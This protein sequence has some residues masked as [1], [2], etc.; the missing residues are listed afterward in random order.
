MMNAR[1]SHFDNAKFL[2]IV[3][4]VEGHAIRP[5]I[6]VSPALKAC[7]VWVY[8]FH[9]PAFS[10]LAGYF[11]DSTPSWENLK[12]SLRRVLL[13]YGIFQILYLLYDHLLFHTPLRLAS[14]FQPYWLMWF[15]WS[16]FWWRLMLWGFA[17]LKWPWLWALLVAVGA[18][19]IKRIGD[20]PALFRTLVFFPFFLGGYLLH[21]RSWRV[22]DSKGA[23]IFAALGLLGA[24]F[25]AYAF[26]SFNY[27]WLYGADP[28]EFLGHSGWTA[29]WTRLAFYAVSGVL[30]FAFLTLVPR[31]TSRITQWGTRSLY[32]YLWHGFFVRGIVAVGFYAAAPHAP[33]ELAVVAGAMLLAALL[34]SRSVQRFTRYLVQP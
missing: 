30:I 34:S 1:V 24:G 21:S 26:P 22:I 20:F 13:P 8:L 9:M 7:Y 12:K 25:A 19:Y 32:P 10:L 18:G 14:I 3:L 11:S 23:K 2:L 16:L 29:G 33:R 17:R 5:W 15:L 28:Y 4:V 27:Q 31:S 6:D